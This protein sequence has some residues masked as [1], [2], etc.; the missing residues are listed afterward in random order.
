MTR[1]SAPAARLPERSPSRAA[2]LWLRGALAGLTA[3]VSI[4]VPAARAQDDDS[5]SLIR[6]TEI[7]DILKQDCAPIF[8]AA[9]LNPDE[10]RILIVGDK[11]INAFAST[12]G[13][14]GMSS[15]PIMAINTG[16]IMETKNPDQLLGVI[17]HETGHLAGGHM[18]RDDGQKKALK[19]FL[20]TM[21]LGIMA[22]IAGAPD[23][24][25]ALVYSSSYFATLDYLAYSR[26]QEARADQ[27][28]LTYLDAAGMS[29]KG[30][31]DFFDKFRYQEVFDQARRYPFFQDH[32]LSSDRIEAL[33][34]RAQKLPNYNVKDSPDAQARH[35]L[36]VAKLR[37]FM[38]PP[39]QTLADYPA[40]DTSF[41]A[42]YARAIAYYKANETDRS[43]KAV[44]AL[45]A[46][47]PKDPYLYELKGQVLFD[48]G[49]I[50]ASEEPYRK[51]IELRPD[52]PL[53]QINLGQTLVAEEDPTKL[54]EAIEVL[55]NALVREDDNAFAWRELAQ[56]YDAKGEGGMARLATAEQE[57]ALG[58]MRD[59][60]IFA[61]RARELLPKN[62]PQY[63]RATDIVLVSQPS[64]DDLKSLAREGG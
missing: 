26:E 4:A 61:M 16:L 52:A 19:T 59:A 3:V 62:T 45:I 24:G 44:D 2:A 56:A 18:V 12:G 27:A 23:A 8:R 43:L 9:G 13:N 21:G 34:V 48:S 58:Q 57:F 15:G 38:N 35:D 50:K 47:Y 6:D 32:P 17:A 42:R 40:G 63:R 1:L 30:L 25:A 33:R 22:A 46:D 36:M 37:A 14:V 11:E 39:G 55:K 10:I 5:T 53:L 49:K 29:G 31:V 64:S 28:A 51:S 54:D 20:L 7:E 41:I 60:R